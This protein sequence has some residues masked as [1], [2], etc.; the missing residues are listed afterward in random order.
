MSIK[1]D[2][3]GGGEFADS[4]RMAPIGTVDGKTAC[5]RDG[6]AGGAEADADF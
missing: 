1:N 6:G 2:L 4:L 3:A 5:W